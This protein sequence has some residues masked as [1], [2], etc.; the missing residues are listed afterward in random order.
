MV[1]YHEVLLGAILG[2]GVSI[3]KVKLRNKGYWNEMSQQVMGDDDGKAWKGK[4]NS[5]YLKDCANVKN[6]RKIEF[7]IIIVLSLTKNEMLLNYFWIL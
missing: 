1:W 6:E 2:S 4:G 5:D 7:F 3:R